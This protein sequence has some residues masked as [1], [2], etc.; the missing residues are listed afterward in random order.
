MRPLCWWHDMTLL[1]LSSTW[2]IHSF[3]TFYLTVPKMKCKF[4]QFSQSTGLA[5]QQ[6]NPFVPFY[7]CKLSP[8]CSI[9]LCFFLFVFLFCVHAMG[10]VIRNIQ[11]CYFLIEKLRVYI[12][13]D[14]WTFQHRTYNN[15]WY[16]SLFT[17]S[18]CVDT[19]V[20]N[21]SHCEHQNEGLRYMASISQL[22][23]LSSSSA[24]IM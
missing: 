15:T 1:Q 17:L 12:Y 2:L 9:P 20:E 16:K 23:E 24:C 13:G 8:T 3:G 14:G 10:N 4:N 19:C 11:L 21:L 22:S 18:G 7:R 6:L 5:T